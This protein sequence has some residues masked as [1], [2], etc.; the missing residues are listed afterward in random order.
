MGIIIGP[1]HDMAL[2]GL[3]F[4]L[5]LI[6]REGKVTLVNEYLGKKLLFLKTNSKYCL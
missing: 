5:F 6:T 1:E 3:V 2:P 4:L